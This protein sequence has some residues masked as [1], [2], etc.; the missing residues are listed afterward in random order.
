MDASDGVS[1]VM[2]EDSEGKKYVSWCYATN[3]TFSRGSIVR[4][5]LYRLQVHADIAGTLSISPRAMRRRSQISMHGILSRISVCD[6][7]LCKI[8]PRLTCIRRSRHTPGHRQARP[9]ARARGGAYERYDRCVPSLGTSCTSFTCLQR[10]K[11]RLA[12]MRR[13]TSRLLVCPCSH[14]KAC[15][16]DSAAEAAHGSAMREWF[17]A[18]WLVRV[19][20]V[21]YDRHMWDLLDAAERERWCRR[22]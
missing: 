21:A 17:C 3:H 1:V 7:A 22:C 9:E 6:G 13:L 18:A 11:L 10:R 20:D 2:P 5:N 8:P 14:L 16:A 19:S 15:T 12:R 4:T